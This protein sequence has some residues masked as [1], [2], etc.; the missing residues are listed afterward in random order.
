MPLQTASTRQ[1]RAGGHRGL[2]TLLWDPVPEGPSCSCIRCERAAA[3][4]LCQAM[5]ERPMQLDACICWWLNANAVP[6]CMAVR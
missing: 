4:G 5:K 3:D 1:H 6:P 2:L